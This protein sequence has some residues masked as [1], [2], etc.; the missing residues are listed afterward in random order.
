MKLFHGDPSRDSPWSAFQ[1]KFERQANHSE[2]SDEK[3]SGRL[4]DCLSGTALEF[5][6]KYAGKDQFEDLKKDLGQRFD[7]KDTPV[8]AH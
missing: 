4:Y 5:S 7:L 8:A 6:N 1:A 3:K 2:W